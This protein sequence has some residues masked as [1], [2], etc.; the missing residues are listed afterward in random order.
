M[1]TLSVSGSRQEGLR[2]SLVAWVPARWRPGL[3][4]AWHHVTLRGSRRLVEWRMRWK[5]RNPRTFNQRLHYKMLHDR[6]PL[7]TSLADKVALRDHITACAGTP[8][9]SELLAVAER[10]EDIPWSD[11]PR[12][13]VIKVNH[14]SGG[15]VMVTSDAPMDARLPPVGSRTDWARFRV[16]P[17]H[18]DAERIADLC[19][20]WLT[21]DYSWTRGQSSIQWCYQ[22][23]PRRIMSEELLRNDA[24]KHPNEYRLFV[25]NGTVRFIQAEID[26]FGD[27]RT[28]VMSPEWD[29]L[30]VRFVDPPPAMPPERPENL[31]LMIMLAEAL[32]EVVV[33]FVRVDLYDLG[34]RIVVGEMTHYPSGGCAPMSSRAY[35]KLWGEG[36]HQEYEAVA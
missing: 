25:I 18:A 20:H 36:W 32:A 22:D 17:E 12:E 4:F 8:Y 33:D 27:H 11:L 7:V 30:P 13:Y 3:R 19:S 5:A 28:A 1:T 34:S 15:I 23:I 2:E 29:V 24:G 31:G 16:R 9:I 26:V 10:T 35:A 21:L 14:G 6:R